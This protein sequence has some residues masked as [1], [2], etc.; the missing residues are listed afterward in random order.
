MKRSAVI[1]V[2]CAPYFKKALQELANLRSTE[3]RAFTMSELLLNAVCSQEGELL[4]MVARYRDE[5][6][7]VAKEIAEGM[8][9]IQKPPDDQEP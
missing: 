2:R 9:S 4:K 8:D 1:H 3:E 5:D 7:A 6:E